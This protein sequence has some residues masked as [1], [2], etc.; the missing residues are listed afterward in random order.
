MYGAQ[1]LDQAGE[2]QRVVHQDGQ[3][4]VEKA[5]VRVNADASQHD[6]LFLGDNRSNVVDNTQIVLADNVERN[7]V[8]TL[9]FA[10]PT[11]F[12]DA[13]TATFVECGS[14]RAALR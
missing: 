3:Y 8:G 11:G 1:F 6:V 5:I 4:A 12:H 10:S 9:S 2:S 14:V 13:V 7:G